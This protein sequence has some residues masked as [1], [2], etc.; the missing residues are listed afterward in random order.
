MYLYTGCRLRCTGL[1]GYGSGG[2]DRYRHRSHVRSN[3]LSL[4]LSCFK[5]NRSWEAYSFIALFI[6]VV[7][8]IWE[9]RHGLMA[10]FRGIMAD[11]RGKGV[12]GM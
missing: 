4:S 10:I 1:V 5:D 8:P 3:S 11:V 12:T 7:M 2:L 6:T 9:S